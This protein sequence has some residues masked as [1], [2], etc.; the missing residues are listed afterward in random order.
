MDEVEMPDLEGLD[1]D[2]DLLIEKLV[3]FKAW[4]RTFKQMHED[5]YG[6][7]KPIVYPED[8]EDCGDCKGDKC[9]SPLH[10]QI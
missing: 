4:V 1:L 8:R 2:T 9:T 10:K 5:K 7:D 3:G 6:D